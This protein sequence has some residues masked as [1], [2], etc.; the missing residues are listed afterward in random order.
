MA[1]ELWANFKPAAGNTLPLGN[2][3]GNNGPELPKNDESPTTVNDCEASTYDSEGD[4]NRTRNHRIDSSVETLVFTGKYRTMI[5][6]GAFISGEVSWD[7]KAT[8]GI[9]RNEKHGW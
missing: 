3:H 4:G 7:G 5:L 2:T 1:D 6:Y 8:L 9:G